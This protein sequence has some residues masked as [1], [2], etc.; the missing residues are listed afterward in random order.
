M[1]LT[2]AELKEVLAKVQKPAQY[3]GEEWQAVKKKHA[4]LSMALVFPDLYEVGMASLGWQILYEI[5]NRHSLY[6]AERIFAPAADMEKLLIEKG[7]KPFSLE[8]KKF[9]DEFDI[10]GFS[11]AHELNY[12]NV[13]NL[14]SLGKIP[15]HTS[16]RDE[17]FPLIIAGGPGIANPLPLKPFMDAFFLGK[18]KPSS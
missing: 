6:K 12:T 5:I 18:Q 3:L 4:L 10:V 17:K 14:L 15:L 13:L 9:I 2:Y 1:S 16:E 8:S 7:L 11:V